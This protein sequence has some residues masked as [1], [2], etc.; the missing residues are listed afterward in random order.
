MMEPEMMEFEVTPKSQADYVKA[1]WSRQAALDKKID[2]EVIPRLDKTN[3]RVRMLER[4]M[5]G[6]GGGLVVIL[7]WVLP[8]LQKTV[9]SIT[10]LP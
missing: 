2:D 8:Q 3:G 10:W 6:I 1:I 9:G 5:W 4:F 7:Y